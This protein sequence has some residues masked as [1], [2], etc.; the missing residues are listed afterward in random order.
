MNPVLVN[1]SDDREPWTIAEAVWPITDPEEMM[2]MVIG[3][4]T[5]DGDLSDEAWLVT[6]GHEVFR[7]SKYRWTSARDPWDD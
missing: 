6:P 4:C 7:V 2:T 1:S 5:E 3:Y